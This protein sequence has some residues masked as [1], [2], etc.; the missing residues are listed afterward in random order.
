LDRLAFITKMSQI[1]SIFFEHPNFISVNNQA[2][3]V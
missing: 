1:V 2:N 3:I